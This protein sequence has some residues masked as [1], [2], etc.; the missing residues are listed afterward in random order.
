MDNKLQKIQ[1][2]LE[3]F[4]LSK[5][6]VLI[7]VFLV[8]HQENRIQEISNAIQIPRSSVYE[9]LKGLQE[10]G[11]IEEI[12]DDHFKKYRPYSINTIKHQVSDKIVQFQKQLIELDNIEKHLSLLP[13]TQS[14]I[15]T[16]VRYY[17]GISGARQLLWN[18]LR[19][20]N[21]VYVYSAW[22]RGRYV[23]IKF[24][25]S[26]VSESKGRKVKE[27]VVVNPSERLLNS[28]KKYVGS[29]VSRTAIADI[30]A[31]NPESILIKGETF[32]YNNIFALIY[33]QDEEINGFEIESKNFTETQRSIFETLWKMAKPIKALL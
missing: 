9:S 19:A 3:K 5:N 7:Y 24:Y 6:Q 22:G 26:F 18:T 21:T 11:L 20:K 16:S 8:T 4:G 23:G 13:K 31:V 33:L 10:V 12:I 29:P 28:I 15:S 30:R 25:K 17:K 27:R 32:I 2:E 14:L 1:K